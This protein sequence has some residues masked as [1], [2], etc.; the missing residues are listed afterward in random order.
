MEGRAGNSAEDECAGVLFNPF[1][2]V[3]LQARCMFILFLIKLHLERVLVVS[4]WRP[5]SRKEMLKFA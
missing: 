3:T 5:A 2:L 4:V 1:A